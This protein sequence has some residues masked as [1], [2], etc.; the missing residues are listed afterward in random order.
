MKKTTA[1]TVT[2]TG[3]ALNTTGGLNIEDGVLSTDTVTTSG[4]PVTFGTTTPT[5]GTLQY[6]GASG[7]F[8]TSGDDHDH[9][10]AAATSTSPSGNDAHLRR[11]PDG[12]RLRSPRP[13]PAPCT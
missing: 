4:G 5:K 7:T 3:V 12:H 6:R 8:S 1:G 10:R 11:Q 2:I 9:L 13:A